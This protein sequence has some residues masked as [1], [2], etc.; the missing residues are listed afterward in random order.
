MATMRIMGPAGHDTLTWDP[1]DAE[2]TGVAKSRFDDL[3][4][5]GYRG[6]EVTGVGKSELMAT[7]D[8]EVEDVVMIRPM[9]GGAC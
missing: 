3:Q 1:A 6:C 7:F 8:P 9:A 4:A 2:S 5:Q